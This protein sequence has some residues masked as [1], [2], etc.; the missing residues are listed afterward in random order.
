M[1]DRNHGFSLVELSIVLVILGLLVGGILSGRSLIA[2]ATI[3]S[4]ISQISEISIA[5]RTFRDKYFYLPRGQGDGDGIIKG[6]HTMSGP[7]QSKIRGEP[8]LFW[9]DL[10]TAGLIAGSFTTA[11]ATNTMPASSDPN[12]IMLYMPR[13]KIDTSFIFVTG[14][15]GGA[16]CGYI[17]DGKSYLALQSVAPI[18]SGTVS[19]AFGRN[20]GMTVSQAYMIDSK[21]D[22]GNPIQGKVAALFQNGT[23]IQGGN[24]ICGV[25]TAPSTTTCS[26]NNNVAAGPVTYSMSVNNGEGLNCSLFF[27]GIN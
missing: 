26:D 3:K 8:L 4:Q 17:Q 16:D 27:H 24:A 2:A 7:G 1:I 9:T 5:T 10:S 21:F 11:T 25:A 22:D 18:G 6:Y 20:A 23:T 19:S 13:G 14:G 15:V 12:D